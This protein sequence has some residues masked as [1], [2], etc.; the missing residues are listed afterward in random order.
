LARPFLAPGNSAFS[1]SPPT[2][3]RRVKKTLTMRLAKANCPGKRYIPASYVLRS[4]SIFCLA[5]PNDGSRSCLYSLDRS[6]IL[7][8]LSSNFLSQLTRVMFVFL[9]FSVSVSLP[10]EPV[11][12]YEFIC[13][14]LHEAV[15]FGPSAMSASRG[16]SPLGCRV[17]H[18]F[19]SLTPSRL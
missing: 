18:F 14:P 8:V 16:F 5:D 13:P 7:S 11:L 15:L 9:G 2:P 1:L 4:L 19:K 12:P 10:C 3:V 17:P 6:R